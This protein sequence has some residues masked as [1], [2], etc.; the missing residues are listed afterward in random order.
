MPRW[1]LREEETKFPLIKRIATERRGPRGQVL[2][3]EMRGSMCSL[4]LLVNGLPVLRGNDSMIMVEM[5]Q[6]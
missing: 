1:G 6:E 3:T 5:V 2:A 4:G